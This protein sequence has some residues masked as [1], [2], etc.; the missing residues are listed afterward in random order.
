MVFTTEDIDEIDNTYALAGYPK[1]DLFFVALLLWKESHCD[2][3]LDT[4]KRGAEN[5]SCAACMVLYV[6]LQQQL[7]GNY[8]LSTPW[9]LEVAIRGNTYGMRRIANCYQ[10]TKPAFAVALT[11]FWTKQLIECGET[12]N[13]EEERKKVKKSIANSCIICSKGNNNDVTLV[14]CGICKFYSYCR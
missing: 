12:F 2:A 11:S 14:K 6:S 8:H 5:D 10:K 7:R 3:A 1:S 13:S 9:A 4:F